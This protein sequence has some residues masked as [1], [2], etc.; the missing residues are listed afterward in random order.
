MSKLNDIGHHFELGPYE[1]VRHIKNPSPLRF[2][3]TLMTKTQKRD[4]ARAVLNEWLFYETILSS[5]DS[6]VNC[7]DFDKFLE[8]IGL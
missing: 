2:D 6:S 1:E 5:C 4:F 8:S 7:N 3:V